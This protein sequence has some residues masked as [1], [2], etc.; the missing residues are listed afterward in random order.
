M[1]TLSVVEGSG[2]IGL[3]EGDYICLHACVC[4]CVMKYKLIN[5]KYHANYV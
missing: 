2:Q 1:L 3:G 5:E 4:V